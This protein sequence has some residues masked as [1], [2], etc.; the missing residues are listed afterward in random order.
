MSCAPAGRHGAVRHDDAADGAADDAI[1]G[2]AIGTDSDAADAAAMHWLARW[3]GSV[4]PDVPP[5]RGTEPVARLWH[6]RP[7]GVTATA[8]VHAVGCVARALLRADAVDDLVR[9]AT[10]VLDSLT[11]DVGGSD[12]EDDEEE[13]EDEDEDGDDDGDGD[14]CPYVH[15]H[16][17]R[18]GNRELVVHEKRSGRGKTVALHISLTLLSPN[19]PDSLIQ[20]VL[21]DAILATYDPQRSSSIRAYCAERLAECT[22]ALLTVEP[23]KAPSPG[24]GDAQMSVVHFADSSALPPDARAWSA[25]HQRGDIDRTAVELRHGGS[26]VAHPLEPRMEEGMARMASRFLVPLPPYAQ[27]RT[28]VAA[29][30]CAAALLE[31]LSALERV[32]PLVGDVARS[33]LTCYNRAHVTLRDGAGALLATWFDRCRSGDDCQ[34]PDA[35]AAAVCSPL[36][37]PTMPY[38]VEPDFFACLSTLRRLRD[39]SNFSMSDYLH[40]RRAALVRL[41][42]MALEERFRIA[43]HLYEMARPDWASNSVFHRDQANPFVLPMRVH[44]RTVL[45]SC[46]RSEWSLVEA[47]LLGHPL[48]HAMN[49]LVGGPRAPTAETPSEASSPVQP[50]SCRCD[51]DAGDVLLDAEV[52]ACVLPHAVLARVVQEAQRTRDGAPAHLL[53]FLARIQPLCALR[54]GDERCDLLVTVLYQAIGALGTASG[55]GDGPERCAAAQRTHALT[56]FVSKLLTSTASAGVLPPRQLLDAC[57]LPILRREAARISCSPVPS[58]ECVSVAAE[59]A[60]DLLGI[61]IPMIQSSSAFLDGLFIA[62]LDVLDMLAIVDRAASANA[63]TI[64]RAGALVAAYTAYIVQRRWPRDLDALAWIM[65]TCGMDWHWTTVALLYP[66]CPV[67]APIAVAA[68]LAAGTHLV[69]ADLAGNASFPTQCLLAARCSDPLA[70]ALAR[71]LTAVRDGGDVEPRQWLVALV[72]LLPT[73][74]TCEWQRISRRLLPAVCARALPATQLPVVAALTAAM[75]TQELTLLAVVR[76]LAYALLMQQLGPPFMRPGAASLEQALRNFACT[77]KTQLEDRPSGAEGSCLQAAVYTVI[78]R[79]LRVF[80]CNEP[81]GALALQLLSVVPQTGVAYD[82]AVAA[83]M[84]LPPAWPYAALRRIHGAAGAAPATTAVS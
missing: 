18:N 6:D 9:F 60:T 29:C 7:V 22:A 33:V 54:S 76:L 10:C 2:D 40:V 42:R 26:S 83:T 63:S 65:T 44:R 35:C 41:S 56:H 13:D 64:E 32:D 81:L 74:T 19:M 55:T 52:L 14:Q 30:K 28:A 3:R 61:V 84:Q 23:S 12:G 4:A 59:A 69:G 67:R 82:A 39:A 38:D 20:D 50:D 1:V 21:P 66:Q 77:I 53:A 31:C 57:L 16:H 24:V 45:Q 36:R 47:D 43:I 71:A 62:M 37:P 75:T 72:T 70:D 5:Q 46:D 80:P 11:S 49:R 17:S 8:L 27:R 68:L 58:R 73:C 79:L 78:C 15:H 25:S 48:T 34:Q 51:D